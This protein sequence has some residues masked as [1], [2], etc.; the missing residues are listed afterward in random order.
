MIPALLVTNGHEG[1]AVARGLGMQ[2]VPVVVLAYGPVSVASS[3]YV[4][5]KIDIPSPKEAEAFVG[6]LLEIGR[7]YEGSLLVTGQ[8]DAVVT[9]SRNKE[10]LS[11]CFV[12]ASPEWG[13]AKRFIDKSYT[14]A[15]ADEIGVPA[16][17]TLSPTHPDEVSDYGKVVQYPCLI[18]PRQVHLFQK[19]FRAKMFLVD[20]FDELMTKYQEVSQANIEV[21]IQE[22]I[23]GEDVDV[24]NYN[25]YIA[26]GL[27]PVEFTAVHIRNAPP[28][29]GSPRVVMSQNIPEITEP[30]RRLLEAMGFNGFSCTE[31]KKDSRDGVFKLMEVNGRHNRS[32]ML[33]IRC[34]INFPWIEYAHLVLG[35]STR[36]SGFEEGVYWM[37][38][39]L[40]IKSSLRYRREERYSLAQ[41]V[42]PYLK[43][44]V[45]NF[46]NFRDLGP[47]ARR[48]LIGTRRLPKRL[49][50]RSDSAPHGE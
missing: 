26:A 14:Y 48:I 8:D 38:T 50:A 1:L 39:I 11:S 42:E 30:G 33:A 4:Q 5:A 22:F 2:G 18:K 7:D 17:K 34:G 19:L 27:D 40:D 12:V 37:D 9:I 13:I 3:K 36:P 49:F 31:F 35:E 32:A 15:L 6:K 25:S 16:P 21:M 46:I 45:D 24:V 29:L 28:Q 44:H 41:Y 10:A 43:P 20:D 47:I 23:P